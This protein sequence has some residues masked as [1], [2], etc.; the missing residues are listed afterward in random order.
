MAGLWMHGSAHLHNSH[1]VVLHKFVL[2]KSVQYF[3]H[4]VVY[5]KIITYLCR[6][7]STA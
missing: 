5:P 6:I 3:S 2:H 7:N 4:K 1:N